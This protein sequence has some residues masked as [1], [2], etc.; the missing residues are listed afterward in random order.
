MTGWKIFAKHHLGHNI[1]GGGMLAKFGDYRTA[2]NLSIA[3][4]LINCVGWG[5]IIVL[6]Q[7][8]HLERITPMLGIL[9]AIPIGLWLLSNLVRYGGA[10]F[11]VFWAAALLWPMF[12]SLSQLAQIPLVAFYIVSAALCLLTAAVLLLSKKFAIEFAEARA[13]RPK[14]K[15]FLWRGLLAAI[16]V[17]MV[18]ATYNDIVNLAASS[19]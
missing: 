8:R 17:A 2:L 5:I 13:H 12:S 16:I 4:A 10:A 7:P 9:V 1:C 3:V 19:P 18:L 15:L 11:M 6:H 14:Y